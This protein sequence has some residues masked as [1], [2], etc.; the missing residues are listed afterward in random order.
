MPCVS[1]AELVSGSRL[2]GTGVKGVKGESNV[3]VPLSASE[4]HGDP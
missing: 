2:S 3:P 4:W 1:C